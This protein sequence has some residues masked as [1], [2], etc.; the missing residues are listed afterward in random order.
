MDTQYLFVDSRK[1]DTR[2]YPNSNNYV[3]FL[4]EPL[5]DVIQVDVI[6]ANMNLLTTTFTHVFLDIEQ[7]ESK[8]GLTELISNVG[9]TGV[10]SSVN[11]VS[12]ENSYTNVPLFKSFYVRNQLAMF[13]VSNNLNFQYTD[14]THFN[15]TIK[16]QQP[17]EKISQMNILWVDRLN[18]PIPFGTN[19]HQFMLRVSTIPKKMKNER[20][21]E[22]P[23]PFEFPVKKNPETIILF[24]LAFIVV[25]L[26]MLPKL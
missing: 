17:I 22:L 21:P 6:Y 18:N 25:I 1:R 4:Q 7:L 19:G 14:N 23:Q 26:C 5:R 8:F 13:P 16:F 3:M 24:S 10:I 15:Q 20:L 11:T 2:V 9:S 12:G